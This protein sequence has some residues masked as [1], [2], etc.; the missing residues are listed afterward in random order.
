MLLMRGMHF[1]SWSVECRMAR[2]AKTAMYLSCHS[3]TQARVLTHR[4]GFLL[5]HKQQCS[6][7]PARLDENC[8]FLP[9]I[10]RSH[11]D[12]CCPQWLVATVAA[13]VLMV[14]IPAVMSARCPLGEREPTSPPAGHRRWLG[15]FPS[16]AIVH[17]GLLLHCN[18]DFPHCSV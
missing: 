7:P 18:T 16:S 9:L 6:E 8:L 5:W 2:V 14:G 15:K 11:P 4:F 17:Q 13:S 10:F 3:L 1:S 12:L